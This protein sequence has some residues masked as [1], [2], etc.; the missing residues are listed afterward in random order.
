[1]QKNSTFSFAI[2]RDFLVCPCPTLWEFG[3]LTPPI[4]EKLVIDL[5]PG[6]CHFLYLRLMYI[7]VVWI[8]FYGK[9]ALQ[10]LDINNSRQV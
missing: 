10:R 7:G 6:R 3:T 9:G 1:M 4:L 8:A 5:P 2:L